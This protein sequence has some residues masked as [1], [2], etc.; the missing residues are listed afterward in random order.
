M[1][2]DQ[3]SSLQEL[4]NSNEEESKFYLPGFNFKVPTIQHTEF[5]EPVLLHLESGEPII[6]QKVGRGGQRGGRK[7]ARIDDFDVQ[8]RRLCMLLPL[9]QD[10]HEVTISRDLLAY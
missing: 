4:L 8:Y 6:M 7:R 5:E 2:N 10:P 3:G 9:K 1:R